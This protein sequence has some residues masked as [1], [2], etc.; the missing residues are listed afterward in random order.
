[1]WPPSLLRAKA[2]GKCLLLGF[3]KFSLTTILSTAGHVFFGRET[4]KG[5]KKNV[6]LN[7]KRPGRDF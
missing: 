6:H 4:G 2:V 5:K 7:F 1:M 3:L